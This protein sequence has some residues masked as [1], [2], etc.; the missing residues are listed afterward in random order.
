ME[1]LNLSKVQQ[2]LKFTLCIFLSLIISMTEISMP[3][4]SLNTI[5]SAEAASPALLVNK[6]NY[7]KII[8]IANN[9]N[10]PITSGQLVASSNSVL[11][12]NSVV[13][14][15]LLSDNSIFRASLKSL[16]LSK[17]FENNPNLIHTLVP[18]IKLIPYLSLIGD[19]NF[20]V[21]KV[22][23]NLIKNDYSASN[24]ILYSSLISYEEGVKAIESNDYD[25]AIKNFNRALSKTGNFA[26]AYVALGNIYSELGDIQTIMEDQAVEE[27]KFYGNARRY[28]E[29]AEE[30]Q[31]RAMEY[32]N[33]AMEVD[34]KLKNINEDRERY[35]DPLLGRAAVY[36]KL[37]QY[38]KALDDFNTAIERN[39]NLIN[40][41]I[42]RATIYIQ[43]GE[44]QKAIADL[45]ESITYLDPKDPV[46]NFK[47]GSVK[48]ELKNY[49]DAIQNFTKVIDTKNQDA[50]DYYADAY[51]KRGIA[52][53]NLK[54]Y[55]KAVNDFN[56]AIKHDSEY[57]AAYYNRG[58]AMAA[59]GDYE[60]ATKD[61]QKALSI[62]PN[63]T[64][65]SNPSCIARHNLSHEGGFAAV[66]S[67]AI[68]PDGKT[69]ASGSDDYTIKLWNIETGKE[70][71][72]LTGHSSFV[73]TVS[74]SPD[75]K[76][77]ASGSY[78]KTIKLWNVA[79]GKEIKTLT[80]HSDWVRTV[81]FSPDGKTLASGSDDKTRV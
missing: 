3:G 13:K 69:L 39:P 47:L 71:K 7:Q 25:E 42:G 14:A 36:V 29:Q 10:S 44:L 63:F 81:S 34:P 2:F 20:F 51:Y 15:S 52:N 38:P 68:S 75:G 31:R 57:V 72:T 41:Y 4:L 30:Y 33:K 49:E 78:D 16:D 37:E 54:K 28:H 40:G 9:S 60:K 46:A 80:G 64:E 19:I 55:Q 61:C 11:S 48:G 66:N 6:V 23:I 26:E 74:F 58:V 70:I 59:L 62:N 67:V 27:G 35:I 65:I 45:T 53:L 17:N 56:E 1:K 12:D 32:Y 43:Q 21:D 5:R 8:G 76:T 22:E 24:P 77:L 79:T 18:T 73:F 50:A